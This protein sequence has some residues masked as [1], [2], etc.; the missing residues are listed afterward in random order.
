MKVLIDIPKEM[1]DEMYE[2]NQG[3]FS[4][5]VSFEITHNYKT[6]KNRKYGIKEAWSN[7]G[8]YRN[9]RFVTMED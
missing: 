4:I 5:D 7:D 8:R 9:I 1:F 3:N 6:T 2:E